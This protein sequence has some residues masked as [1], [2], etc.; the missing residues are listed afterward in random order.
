[1]KERIKL[2]DLSANAVPH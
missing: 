2:S 1:M